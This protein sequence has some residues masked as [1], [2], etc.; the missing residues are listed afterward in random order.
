[1]INN[2]NKIADVIDALGGRVTTAELLEVTPNAVSNWASDGKFPS[3]LYL[4]VQ[5]EMHDRNLIA[6]D[7]LFKMR[8]RKRKARGR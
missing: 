3:E 4:M 7:H 6:P 8:K 2:L 1:M 5:E